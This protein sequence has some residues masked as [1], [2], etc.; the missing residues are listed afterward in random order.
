VKGSSAWGL[1][2]Y[3]SKSGAESGDVLVLE[4]CSKDK[5]AV[6]RLGDSTLLDEMLSDY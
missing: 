2:G 5:S 4:I 6:V 1:A 3:L